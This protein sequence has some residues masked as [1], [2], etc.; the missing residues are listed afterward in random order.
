MN[1]LCGICGKEAKETTLSLMDSI[2]ICCL[3]LDNVRYK[4]ENNRN[5]EIENTLIN[6]VRKYMEIDY[7]LECILKRLAALEADKISVSKIGGDN[8]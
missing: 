5:P 4:F 6:F 7:I 1:N 2:N 3:C 8:G